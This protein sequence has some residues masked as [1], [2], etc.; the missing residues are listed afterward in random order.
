LSLHI[1]LQK[2]ILPDLIVLFPKVQFIITTHSPFFL[3]GLEEKKKKNSNFDYQII[4][5]PD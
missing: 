4:K 2:T 5:L 3:L 1:E